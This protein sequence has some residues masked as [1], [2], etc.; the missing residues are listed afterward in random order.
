[1][2]LSAETAVV[3]VFGVLV[4]GA[5]LTTA[6]VKARRLGAWL[7]VASIMA[8]LLLA[9]RA[10]LGIAEA[11]EPID[12]TV[13]RLAIIGSS[14][15]VHFDWLSA[16]LAFLILF[17]GLLC[18]GYAAHYIEHIKTPNVLGFWPVYLCFLA[19]M[20]GVVCVSDLLFF[21]VMWEFMSLPA[22]ALIVYEKGRAENLRAGLKYLLMTHIANVG[23]IVGALVLYKHSHSFSYPDLTATLG[24]LSAARPWL[25]N[26]VLA[27]MVLAF[28]T[29][30]GLFPVGDWLPDAHPAAPS[31]VSAMLSGVMVKLGAYAVARLFFWI[32]PAGAVP[33]AWLVWWGAVLGAWGAASALVG[34]AAAV[35]CNDSK[36]LLAYSTIG[37]S[38]YIFLA[39]GAALAFSRLDPLISAVALAGALLHILADAAHKSLLFLTAGSVLMRT[40]QRDMDQLGGLMTRMPSTGTA[41]LVGVLS[42]AGIPLTGAFVSKWLIFQTGLFGGLDSPA[43]VAY[44][45]VG[46]FASVMAI[47][48][49][50]KYF[51]AIFLGASP[52]QLAKADVEEVPFGMDFVQLL[53]AA[54]CVLLGVLPMVPIGWCMACLPAPLAEVSTR[55]LA[56]PGL[57]A[58][59]SRLGGAEVSGS[60]APLWVALIFGLCLILSWGLSRMGGAAVRYVRGW[61]CGEEVEP[62]LTRVPA[63]GYFWA[64]AEY[65]AG[66]YPRVG[67]P[68][69]RLPTET[70]PA[71]DVDRWGFAKITRALRRVSSALGAL[72]TG[73]PQLYMLWQALGATVIIF[74]FWLLVRAR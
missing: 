40:G 57:W 61:V 32:L 58:I 11:G 52:A 70:P 5:I 43:F 67:L 42:V 37:Q 30:A 65:L 14:L 21:I 6:C 29:K 31:P 26:L 53:L 48:Y 10:A 24:T 22:Y 15:R 16:L 33:D 39:L 8:A 19:G 20:F 74:I 69:F 12:F 64:A 60:F 63:H 1:M 72:H 54:G 3:W 28:V 27:L 62:R 7:A 34:S 35:T 23:L 55:A 4:V 41:A 25:T 71:L 36:R 73:V 2:E 59:A 56:A 45:V 18:A 66:I 17:L 44:V 51:G 50:L 38:G 13:S 68:A 9:V 47:A 46:L 49:G